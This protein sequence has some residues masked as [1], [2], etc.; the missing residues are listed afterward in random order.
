MNVVCSTMKWNSEQIVLLY[1]VMYLYPGV[2]PTLLELIRFRG[3]ES[4]INI[5]QQIGT[6]F[7]S[8]GTLLLEDKT[9]ARIRS[10]VHE[11][12]DNPEQINM[13][14]LE[15]WIAGR[16]KHPVSWDTL[17]EVLQDIDLHTLASDIA[18]VKMLKSNLC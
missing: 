18:A 7:L 11:C 3:R 5:P 1:S 6:N 14:I 12:R 4:R 16:G 2:Q 8:F 9:G 15:E 17:I 10:I 13:K